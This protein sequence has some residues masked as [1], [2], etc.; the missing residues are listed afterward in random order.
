MIHHDT[1]A[2]KYTNDRIIN[3]NEHWII[4]S[5][6]G[7][8]T[9]VGNQPF[10]KGWICSP[11]KFLEMTYISIPLSETQM[12]S[13]LHSIA[14]FSERTL[15][16]GAKIMDRIIQYASSEMQNWE[17]K[18]DLD[19][20]KN[21]MKATLSNIDEDIEKELI[22]RT[23]QFLKDRGIIIHDEDIDI[24]IEDSVS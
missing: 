1:I 18:N 2:L 16:I 15:A 21:E 8:L 12:V 9:K 4:L 19:N 20:F 24:T 5:Y 11:G 22:T 23:D 3:N 17:F 6:D 14:S 13:V 10:Y 7:I